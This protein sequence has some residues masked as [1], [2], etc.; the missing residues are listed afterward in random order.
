M[1]SLRIGELLRRIIPL[2]QHDV[3]EILSEQQA[4]NRK[5]GDIALALGL[6]QPQHVWRAWM[7]QLETSTQ[8]ISVTTV[9]VDSQ[10]IP[11]LDSHTAHKF[12][13]IPLRS[14]EGELLVAAA[15]PLGQDELSEIESVCNRRVKT[16]LADEADVQKHLHR[17]YPRRERANGIKIG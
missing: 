7:H 13:I 8:R 17:Y 15:H 16:V 5:F 11:L 12:A 3:E 2:S 14:V 1:E 6:C 4:S 10:A 9:G